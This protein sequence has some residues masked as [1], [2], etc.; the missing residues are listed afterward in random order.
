MADI[1]QLMQLGQQL[2]G[3]LQQMDTDLAERIISADA[4]GGMVRVSVDGRGHLRELDIEPGVFQQG[5]ASFLADLVLSAVAEAQRRA[6]EE[7]QAA[8]K[9]TSGVPFPFS[10]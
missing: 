1:Q 6:E 5:D 4:G 10:L 7:R 9:R 3:R 2:Q 8:L